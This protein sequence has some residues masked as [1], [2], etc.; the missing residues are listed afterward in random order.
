MIIAVV[1]II[2]ALGSRRKPKV[3]GMISYLCLLELQP[4]I[5]SHPILG[6][7]NKVVRRLCVSMP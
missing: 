3:V 5:V 1:I 4:G 6:C 2:S 7:Y